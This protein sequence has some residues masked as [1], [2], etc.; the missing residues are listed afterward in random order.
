MIRYVRS[1]NNRLITKDK[2]INYYPYKLKTNIRATET[3][4]GAAV[5]T[6]AAAGAAALTA[7]A[8]RTTTS[9]TTDSEAATRG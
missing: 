1:Q 9:T 8:A 7:T 4:T 3:A 5:S 6:T 2:T